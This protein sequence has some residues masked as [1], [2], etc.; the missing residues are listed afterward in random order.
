VVEASFDCGDNELERTVPSCAWLPE[1]F[2]F[3][4][5]ALASLQ[6]FQRA[7]ESNNR[8]SY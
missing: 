4:E 3:P 7:S 2:R 8:L 6:P 1:S 5:H